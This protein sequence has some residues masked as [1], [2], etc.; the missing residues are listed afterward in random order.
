MK[1]PVLALP[2]LALALAGCAV[3]PDYRRPQLEAPDRYRDQRQAEA[4]SL[5]DQPWWEVFADPA[6]QDLVAQALERNYDVRVA[7][8]RVDEYRAR[9]GIDQSAYLP[10]VT[11]GVGVIRGR[12]SAFSSSGGITGELLSA[13]VGLSWELDLWGRIRRM[14]E[15]SMA[16]FLATQEARR[17]V[18]LATAAQVAQAYFELC[19]LDARLAIARATAQAYQETYDLFNR[20]FTGGAASGLEI[21][22]AESALDSAAAT[23][24][25]LEQQ[26]KA[27][28]NLLCYLVGRAPGP[29]VRGAG[30]ESQPMPPAIPAGLPSTLLERRPDLRQA[31]QQMKA[32][33]AAIGVAQA[34]YFPTLSLTGMVGGVAPEV[35]Q[36]F[37]L[38]RAWNVGAGLSGPPIQGLKLKYQKQ[39]AVAQWEQAKTR[40]EGAVTSAFGEVSS[41]LVAYQKLAEVEAQL[42]KGVA[43]SQ[44]AVHLATLRYTAGL[45]SYLEVLDAQQQLFPAQILRSQA[46]L[47]RLTTL[48]GLYKALGGGWNLQ[49]PANPGAWAKHP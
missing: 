24:P 14:N 49:D 13:Q 18:F 10:A 3:G 12:N 17:G 6:L 44:E 23:I 19:D 40:Y 48:V 36:M 33:N 39:V 26:I 28:E 47:A 46:R 1:R 15:A 21:A 29:I 38:G 37:G 22:R 20:R 45:S 35:S 27:K 25:N 2:L 31:E 42:T 16:N 9:A 41:L 34:S 43:S 30:M 11:P 7:A 32:A 8:Q 4:A 5:A